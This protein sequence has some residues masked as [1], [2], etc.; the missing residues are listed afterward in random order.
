MQEKG[1]DLLSKLKEFIINE[2]L[3][4]IKRYKDKNVKFWRPIFFPILKSYSFITERITPECFRNDFREELVRKDKNNEI[5]SILDTCGQYPLFIMNSNE[6]NYYKIRQE[7]SREII[8]KTNQFD[9]RT[10]HSSHSISILKRFGIDK[11]SEK[12]DEFYKY[13]K[14]QSNFADF[15]KFIDNIPLRGIKETDMYANIEA[16][17]SQL[18]EIINNEYSKLEEEYRNNEELN[19]KLK[20]WFDLIDDNNIEDQKEII[21]FSDFILFI[22]IIIPKILNYLL[23]RFLPRDEV[24]D[25]ILNEFSD[26]DIIDVFEIQASASEYLLVIHSDSLF[27]FFEMINYMFDEKGIQVITTKCVLRLWKYETYVPSPKKCPIFTFDFENLELTK[28]KKELEKNLKEALKKELILGTLWK[29]PT[30]I[31]NINKIDENKI[32]RLTIPQNKNLSSDFSIPKLKYTLD[33]F[34]DFLNEKNIDEYVY[35]LSVRLERRGWFKILIMLKAYPGKKKHV[36]KIIDEKILGI[37]SNSFARKY[38]TIRGLFD[39]IIYMDCYDIKSLYESRNKLANELFIESN[40]INYRSYIEVDE[41]YLTDLNPIKPILINNTNINYLRV[42]I[43]NAR[44]LE[45][46]DGIPM[47]TPRRNF[48]NLVD[49]YAYNQMNL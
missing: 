4:F 6:D 30:G 32:L 21:H 41:E 22:P 5:I 46:P 49:P 33:D 10:E 29:N 13:F 28:S 8:K 45:T 48:L 19:S 27:E 17:I 15:I 40:I 7:V 20:W 1:R 16:K 43:A 24:R 23:I 18:K 35:K 2:Q 39:F 36:E 47:P 11:Y 44:D 9:I 3:Q 38:Y 42:I 34:K 12:V 14:R 25:K 31:Y 26:D 37:E